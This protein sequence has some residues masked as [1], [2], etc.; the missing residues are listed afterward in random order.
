[1][2]ERLLIAVVLLAL[3]VIAYRLMIRRQIRR[4]S[5]IAA[6]GDPLLRER[7]PGVPSILYF[8]T[9]TCIP[10]RTQQTP[11]LD[12]L[13]AELGDGVH[14]VKVDATENPD[15]A[16]RW[17]VFSSPTTF[18]IDGSGTTRAVNHGVA[19]AE[20]LRKQLQLDVQVA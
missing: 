2:I 20:K 7:R 12:R 13:R 16:E 3:G 17:G 4:T 1:M 15:A 9:P 6:V 5:E 10:C 18:V 14:I 11:A 19:D 8:T